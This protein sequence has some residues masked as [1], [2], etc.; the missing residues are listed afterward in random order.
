[1]TPDKFRI[2]LNLLKAMGDE[3][4]LTMIRLLNQGEKNV[5]E[6]AELLGISEPTVSHH[7][8]KLRAAGL[9]NLR[10]AGNQRI[11]RLN[12]SRLN[13]FKQY[14]GQIEQL[15]PFEKPESDDSWIDALDLGEA[16][17]KV[18]LDYTF[19]GRLRKIPRKQGKLLVILDWL[20]A[21]F[22]PGVTYS[23]KEINTI[24]SEYH[25]DFAS[26]RRDMVDFGYLRRERAGTAYWVTPKDEATE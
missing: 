14:A 6:L 15:Q 18:L 20:A 26:L 10:T 3:N 9:V 5:T 25:P 11:Y 22:Q 1:M 16:E 23:E 19:N 7:L 21:K 12:P 8:S 13:E 24:L 2:M 17:R 4:R